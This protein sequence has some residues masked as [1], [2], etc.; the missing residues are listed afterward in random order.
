MKAMISGGDLKNAAAW[1]NKIA[2]TKPIVP[3]TAFAEL[4]ADETLR[5]SSTDLEV[6]GRVTASATVVDGGRMLVSA[7]LL[8]EISKLLK[9]DDE[10]TLIGEGSELT[11]R[12]GRT[13]WRLPTSD[14]IPPLWP[15]QGA[16]TGR[17]GSEQLSRALTSVLHAVSTDTTLQALTGVVMEIADGRLTLAGTDRYRLAVARP[18]GWQPVLGVVDQ[19]LL[20]P[21]GLMRTVADALTGSGEVV[22]SAGDNTLTAASATHLVT[23][24]LL[25]DQPLRW[26]SLI[27]TARKNIVCTV[28]ADT[29]ELLAAVRNVGAVLEGSDEHRRVRLEV[30]GEEIRIV[31]DADDSSKAAGRDVVTAVSVEGDA[32]ISVKERWLRESLTSAGS[33]AVTLALGPFGKP[34]LM[35]PSAVE[36]QDGYECLVMTAGRSAAV[37]RAAA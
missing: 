11:I 26:K 2:P 34:F 28:T 31:Q 27:D 1:A 29:A 17:I 37:V 36:G 13:V 30:A 33:P 20:P 7:R 22:L 23:A 25:A 35:R 6:F 18:A 12:R 14:E 21:G 16:E 15:D 19:T 24:R 8:A 10:V 5:L 3:V 9:S 4:V 32:E